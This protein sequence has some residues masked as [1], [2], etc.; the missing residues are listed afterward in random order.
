MGDSMWRGTTG[1]QDV[2]GL[3]GKVGV[4]E[5]GAD[6]APARCLFLSGSHFL[7]MLSEL[8]VQLSLPGGWA[9]CPMKAVPTL[10]F[11]DLL[12]QFSAQ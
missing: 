5:Q 8:T 1:G 12:G 10:Y 4:L 9:D 2:L 3:G 11:P 7:F 6:S